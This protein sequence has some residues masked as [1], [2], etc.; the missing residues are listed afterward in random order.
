MH[1]ARI[2]RIGVDAACRLMVTG[3]D[4]KTARLWAL[5]EDAQI[6]DDGQH[7]RPSSVVRWHV[8]QQALQDAQGSRIMFVDTCH[9]RGAYNPRLIKDAADSRTLPTRISSYSRQLTAQRKLRREASSATGFSPTRSTRAQWR[10][11][12]HEERRREHFGAV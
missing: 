2:W 11:G 10:C 6:T 12:F 1:G 9:S 4:D 5:P 3:S 8:L 7:W